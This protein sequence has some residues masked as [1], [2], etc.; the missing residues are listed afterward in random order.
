MRRFLSWPTHALRFVWA[1]QRCTRRY[2]PE[3]QEH[4]YAKNLS[5][6]RRHG[7]ALERVLMLDDTPEK[8]AQHYGNHIRIPPFTGDPADR[9]LPAL[10]PFLDALRTAENVRRIEKRYWQQHR[11]PGGQTT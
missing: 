10:L 11:P 2:H 1:R 7:H 3:L 9:Q 5:K 6:L 8:V 4:Y